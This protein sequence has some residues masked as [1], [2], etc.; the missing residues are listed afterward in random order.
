MVNIHKKSQV[1]RILEEIS[2][3]RELMMDCAIKNGFTCEETIRYSQELD[4]LINT[5]Q[6]ERYHPSTHQESRFSLKQIILRWQN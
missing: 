2:Y 6:R 4:E 5:Y 3:K 1:E